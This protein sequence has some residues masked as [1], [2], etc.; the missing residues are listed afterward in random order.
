[1]AK[2][3]FVKVVGFSLWPRI[4][5]HEIHLGHVEIVKTDFVRRFLVGIAPILFGVLLLISS[6]YLLFTHNL[7]SDYLFIF[8][9]SLLVFEI[10]NTMFMSKKDMEGSWKIIVLGILLFVTL[11]AFG[12]EGTGII[13]WIQHY[14]EFIAHVILYL[15]IPIGLD[16]ILLLITGVFL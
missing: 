6:I 2:I 3:L 9:E 10:G 1:M 16:I 13:P 15:G 12:V 11:Y 4:V 8:L 5:G 14:N 7:Q